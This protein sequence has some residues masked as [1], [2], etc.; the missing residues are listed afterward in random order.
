MYVLESAS[1]RD[2]T[3]WFAVMLLKLALGKRFMASLLDSIDLL[4]NRSQS[5][6]RMSNGAH[7]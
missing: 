7:R 3:P 2:Q 4:L 5:H 6:V 1:A